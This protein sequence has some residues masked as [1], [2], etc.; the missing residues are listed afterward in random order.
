V[1]QPLLQVRNLCVDY[2]APTGFA[3]TVRLRAVDGVSFELPRGSALGIV[4]ESGSGKSSIAR[5]IL[6]LTEA[7]G[8]VRFGNTELLTA[9]RAALRSARRTMQA[10]FQDPIGSLDP[11]MTIADI[12]GEP[13]REHCPELAAAARRA[14]S[15]DALR[16][17]GLSDEVLDRYPH[18]FSGGQAQRIAIA[19]AL[20]VA[21]ELVICDEPLSA[22]DVSIK[23]QIANLLRDLQ[24]QLQLS[25]LIISHD[26]AAVRFCC[27]QVLVL[28]RGQVMEVA[29]TDTLYRDPRHPYSRALL[30][31][32]PVP[33]PQAARQPPPALQGVD[34][35]PAHMGCPFSPR[36]PLAIDRCR[37]ERP[38]PRQVAGSL[39]ACH[40]ADES[41]L[42]A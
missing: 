21:P 3:T 11:R 41:G 12:V 33:D 25:L 19:R 1:S 13:L 30:A 9:D 14:R 29:A 42:P 7:T 4:G 2:R 20:I 38:E 31:A 40:R 35:Q 26:L 17:V 5:A 22:L 34:A 10:I 39:V 18:Q 36:C 27:D 24:R 23:A 28:Y 6:R 32:V 15:V 16:R 37:I 8:S